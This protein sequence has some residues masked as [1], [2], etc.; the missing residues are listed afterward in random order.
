M[1]AY[2]ISHFGKWGLGRFK[3]KAKNINNIFKIKG[4]KHFCLK[5][6]RQY[7]LIKKDKLKFQVESVFNNGSIMPASLNP[8]ALNRQLSHLPHGTNS[9]SFFEL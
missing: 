6:F 5:N 3:E 7:A 2:Q 1:R 4:L 9:A 8:F